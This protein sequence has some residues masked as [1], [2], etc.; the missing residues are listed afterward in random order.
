LR[1]P[2]ETGLDEAAIK[3]FIKTIIRRVNPISKTG[4]KWYMKNLYF[5]AFAGLIFLMFVMGIFIFLPAGSLNFREGWFYYF[6]FFFSTTVITLYFLRKSPDLIDRRTKVGPVAEQQKSQKIIQS[7]ASI[8]FIALLVIP[9][10]DHRFN[11]SHVPFSLVIAANFMVLLGFV[12]I[13]RVFLENS[14]T[15]S[16][17]EV[18]KDQTVVSTGPYRWVRHP[19]YFGGVT[20]IVFT[21]LAM[22]SYWGIWCSIGL[23]AVIVIRLLEEEKFLNKNLIGYKEYCD[24]TKYRLI[25]GIW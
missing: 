24:H 3:F 12:I 21:P 10:L 13:F 22:G 1:S 14:F 9:G 25:P 6:V 15:S 2:S 20:L 18:D 7:F 8:I 23:T 11:W 16:T 5:R 19:M 4:R 17:I